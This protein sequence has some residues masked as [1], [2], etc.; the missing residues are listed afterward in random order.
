MFIEVCISLIL[1]HFIDSLVKC[2]AALDSIW[3][4]IDSKISNKNKLDHLNFVYFKSLFFNIRCLFVN[5]FVNYSQCC[6][7]NKYWTDHL[8]C[9]KCFV[10]NWRKNSL[11]PPCNLKFSEKLLTLH[12]MRSYRLHNIFGWQGTSHPVV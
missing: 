3:K 8:N 11:Y 2:A 10:Y 7:V 5:I 9:C 12:F 6:K 1:D 4:T